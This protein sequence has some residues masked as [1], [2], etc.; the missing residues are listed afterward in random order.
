ML[1]WAAKVFIVVA[2]ASRSIVGEWTSSG[3][4]FGA[5]GWNCVWEFMVGIHNGRFIDDNVALCLAFQVSAHLS[6][7][8]FY[9]LFS[10]LALS[11]MNEDEELFQFF[12]IHVYT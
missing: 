12:F 5:A 2:G 7:C 6:Y 11:I 9:S 4:G 1:Q 10:S 3:G 8:L